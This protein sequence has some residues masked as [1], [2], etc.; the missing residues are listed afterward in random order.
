VLIALAG[1]G[2]FAATVGLSRLALSRWHESEF[3][4]ES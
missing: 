3:D 1:V 2:L 4:G